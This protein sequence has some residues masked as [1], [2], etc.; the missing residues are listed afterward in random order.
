MCSSCGQGDLLEDIHDR[1]PQ[2]EL[3][4]TEYSSQA[5]QFT[6]KRI[7][8]AVITQLDLV[9]QSLDEKFDMVISNDVLE[10][11]EDDVIAIQNLY[12]MTKKYCLIKTIQG[13]FYEYEK[14][15]VGHVRS[16]TREE[17]ENKLTGVGFKLMDIARK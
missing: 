13:A 6:S 9:T 1:Y 11:I 10:H 7:E 3:R 16:Y 14:K 5:V 15:T 2:I 8:D 17:L 12:K 4:G